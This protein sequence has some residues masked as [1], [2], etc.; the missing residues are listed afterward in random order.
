MINDGSQFTSDAP[1]VRGLNA[2]GAS[3][4]SVNP[5]MGQTKPM[6]FCNINMGVH[7][8]P[9]LRRAASFL[10]VVQN[11]HLVVEEGLTAKAAPPYKPRGSEAYSRENTVDIVDYSQ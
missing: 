4:P 7:V 2:N 11:R 8:L 6:T 5:V 10:S 9:S 1:P 3:W